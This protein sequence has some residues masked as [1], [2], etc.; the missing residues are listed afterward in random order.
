MRKQIIIENQLSDSSQGDVYISR[1]GQTSWVIH[2]LSTESS[3][4]AKLILLE[5][6]G[7]LFLCGVEKKWY[8]SCSYVKNS[9]LRKFEVEDVC[10][11][12]YRGHQFFEAYT[13]Q[14]LTA[15]KEVLEKLVKKF[16]IPVDKKTF[17]YNCNHNN[18]KSI[19]YYNERAVAGESGIYTINSFYH[20]FEGIAPLYKLINTLKSIEV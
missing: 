2:N 5:N 14:Q 12:G 4:K 9:H 15:L 16:S 1:T 10:G 11:R 17:D 6:A 7:P 18:N 13:E 8:Q 3:Q 20:S 19:W